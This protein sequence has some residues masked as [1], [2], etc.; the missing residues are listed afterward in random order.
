MQ[1]AWSLGEMELI[2]G[3]ATSAVAHF[4]TAFE[5]QDARGEK[6]YLS[7]IAMQLGEA[8]YRLGQVDEA[9][10]H[11]EITR[12]VAATDD[13]MAQ[14][15]WRALKAKALAARGELDDGVRLAREAVEIAERTDY[16]HW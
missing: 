6:S 15:G 9:E 10:R 11:A 4:T 8:L 12:A 1:V 3:D 14:A 7:G 5:I 16:L 2:A 13:I